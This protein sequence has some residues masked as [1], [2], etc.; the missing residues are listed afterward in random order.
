MKK[1][2]VNFDIEF[3]QRIGSSSETMYVFKSYP[4]KLD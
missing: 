2:T 4:G 3:V 1:N